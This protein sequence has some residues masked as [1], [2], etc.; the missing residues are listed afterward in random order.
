MT[1]PEPVISVA[2]E[3]KS[4][5]DEEKLQESLKKM[6]VED[7]TFRVNINEETGQTLIAGMGELHLEIIVDRLLREHKVNANVGRP[8]VAFKETIM[9]AVKSEKSVHKA[10][11]GKDQYGHIVL[12]VRPLARGQGVVVKKSIPEKTLPREIEDSVYK[13]LKSLAACGPLAGFQM[14]DLEIHWVN[15]IFDPNTSHE[16]AYHQAAAMAFRECVESAKAR[17]IE[18]IMKLQIISPDTSIGDVIS[19]LNS[20]RGKIISLD[21]KMGGIQ[22]VNAEAPLATLFG[23]STDLRSR[24]QGRGTFSMEFLTYDFMSENLEKQVLQKLTGLSFEN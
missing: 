17:L 3:A 23:Y 22:I 6:T 7:P 24:T 14:V 16:L 8:Q 1:F 21:S 5:A 11:A 2:I 10:I 19:D 20:R 15:S 13:N 9:N 12:E 18:P 4:K